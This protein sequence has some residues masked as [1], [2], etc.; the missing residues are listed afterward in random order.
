M[1]GPIS[2][3]TNL[4]NRWSRQQEAALLQMGRR[5]T[6]GARIAGFSK[7]ERADAKFFL[8]AF[9]PAPLLALS[10]QLGFSRGFLWWSCL[11]LSICWWAL[12]MGICAAAYW[13]A[14]RQLARRKS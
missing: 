9:A 4:L 7:S 12:V 5:K 2:A 3:L 14:I 8:L 1:P 13:R 11:T 6:A 10:D